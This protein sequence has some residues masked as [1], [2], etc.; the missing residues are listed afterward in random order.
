MLVVLALLLFDVAKLRRA[1][2]SI[3]LLSYL[4]DQLA[5]DIRQGVRADH[6]ELAWFGDYDFT[7]F[8]LAPKKE[9]SRFK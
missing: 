7:L 2:F 4:V 5:V 3:L 8:A 9:I 6:E 1:R